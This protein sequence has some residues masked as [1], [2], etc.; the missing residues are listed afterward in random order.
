MKYEVEVGGFATVFRKRRLVIHANS[1]KE[2][3][4]K[5]LEKF[6]KLQQQNGAVCESGMIDSIRQI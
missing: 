4:G 2:A 5:A 3:E 1:M 6:V